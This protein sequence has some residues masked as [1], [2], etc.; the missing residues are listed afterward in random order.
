MEDGI[1]TLNKEIPLPRLAKRI[2][3]ISS[4]NAAGYGDFCNQIEQSPYAFVLQLFPAQMQGANVPQS[5]IAALDSIAEQLDQWDAVVIIRG[6][7]ATTD[8]DGFE[9]YELASNVAQFPLPVITGIGHERDETVVDL[10]AGTRCKTPTAVAA[11]LIER[12]QTEDHRL[13]QFEAALHSGTLRALQAKQRTFE[14]L[15]HRYSVGA[16]EF[17]AAQRQRVFRQANRL[18]TAAIQQLADCAHRTAQIAQRLAPA[19]ERMLERATHRL[20]V[21]EKSIQAADP[22]RIL[23]MGYSITYTL[24]G[25][26]VRSEEQIPADTLIET[27][28]AKGIVRS[29][30]VAPQ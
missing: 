3:V 7:G 15:A 28:L 30:V 6:G 20:Q 8:L 13:L 22:K 2:A 25:K 14:L 23:R 26:T 21:A 4:E 17:V 10:V 12:M 9:D 24:D 18:Q 27:H 5:V 11:F 16:T 19:A 29:R 1:F